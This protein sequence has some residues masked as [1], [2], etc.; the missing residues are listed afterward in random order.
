MNLWLCVGDSASSFSTAVILHKSNT[1]IA[2][3]LMLYY[4]NINV[5]MI[6]E[7][8]RKLCST[9]KIKAPTNVVLLLMG[10]K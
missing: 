5:L 4:T 2:L 9:F 1:L 3:E 7:L 6:I 8:Y 10:I